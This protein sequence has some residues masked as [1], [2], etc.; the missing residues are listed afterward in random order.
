MT[1]PLVRTLQSLRDVDGIVGSFVVDADGRLLARDL[2]QYF[3]SAVLDEVGPRIHRLYDAWQSAG[4]AL[5]TATLV[6]ADHKMHLRDLDGSVL[7][8]VSS[9]AV[10]APA[11]KMALGMVGRK[12]VSELSSAPALAPHDEPAPRPPSAAASPTPASTSVAPPPLPSARASDPGLP[13]TA[14]EHASGAPD[15]SRPSSVGR[16]YRGQRIE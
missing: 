1:E 2:P 12:L 13:P 14:A 6:F 4:E 5:D 3:D 16:F 10:N 11:L 8:V 9:L 7:A 15:G